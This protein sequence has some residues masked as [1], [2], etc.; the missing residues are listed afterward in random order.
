ML[1]ITVLA[2]LVASW[3]AEAIQEPPREQTRSE[4]LQG[5]ESRSSPQRGCPRNGETGEGV[6]GFPRKREIK[7][8]EAGNFL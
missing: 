1:L 5:Q 6:R 3:E 2:G 7:S 8:R 4:R